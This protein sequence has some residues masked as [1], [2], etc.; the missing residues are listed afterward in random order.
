MTY[1]CGIRKSEIL[2][3]KNCSSNYG[4]ASIIRSNSG[5]GSLDD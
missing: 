4:R 2:F 5:W 3:L 1:S